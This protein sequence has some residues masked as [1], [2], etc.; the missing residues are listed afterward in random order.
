[1]TPPDDEEPEPASEEETD[2]GQSGHRPGIRD[3]DILVE[4][5]SAADDVAAVKAAKRR[6]TVAAGAAVAPAGP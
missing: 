3:G 2:E 5:G 4:G 6:L 1:M